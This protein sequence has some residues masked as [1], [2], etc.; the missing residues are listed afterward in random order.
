MCC[1]N[2]ALA[3]R[4]NLRV[5]AARFVDSYSRHY[6]N[7]LVDYIVHYTVSGRHYYRRVEQGNWARRYK[8]VA[9]AV[10]GSVL[11]AQNLVALNLV[12]QTPVV[13]LFLGGLHK[14]IGVVKAAGPLLT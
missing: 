13:A 5:I 12:V 8:P 11:V 7:Q 6:Y 4:G 3:A 10:F 14:G 9:E 2:K 1:Y